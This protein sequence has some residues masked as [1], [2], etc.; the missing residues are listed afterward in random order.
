M[1]FS[2]IW[3]AVVRA[4]QRGITLWGEDGAAGVGMDVGRCVAAEIACVTAP[5][6]LTFFGFLCVLAVLCCEYIHVSCGLECWP[7]S[8]PNGNG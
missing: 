7:V 2:K 5:A 1:N 6:V 8:R 3:R 4:A